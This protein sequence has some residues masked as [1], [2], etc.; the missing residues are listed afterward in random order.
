[1]QTALFS[2]KVLR[3][4]VSIL[5]AFLITMIKYLNTAKKKK[6]TLL[7]RYFVTVKESYLS[8]ISHYNK[9]FWGFLGVFFVFLSF[10]TSSYPGKV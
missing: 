2:I 6:K 9:R 5:V 10:F 1:M 8:V 7:I 4:K 3:L